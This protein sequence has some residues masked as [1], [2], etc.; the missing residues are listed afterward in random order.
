MIVTKNFLTLE[1]IANAFLKY[2]D[3]F[4][5]ELIDNKGNMLGGIQKHK[6]LI[7]SPTGWLYEMV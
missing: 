4:Y 3:I 5:I 2:K 1:K 7:L 6:D